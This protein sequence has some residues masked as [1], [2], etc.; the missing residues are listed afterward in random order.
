MIAALA[1]AAFICSEP[2]YLAAAKKAQKFLEEYLTGSN[3]RLF[4]RYCDG[5][6]A[7]PGHLD[8]YAFYA[9]ALTELYQSTWEIE[10]LHKAAFITKQMLHLFSDENS[11]GFYLYAIDAPQ[12][13]SRPKEVYD[14]A[15]PSGN[16]VAAQVLATLASLTGVEYWRQAR[17]HQMCFLADA[18]HDRPAGHCFALSAMCNILYPATNLLCVSAE[19]EM[20]KAMTDILRKK[21]PSNMTVLFKSPGNREELARLAPFTKE[22]PIPENGTL[23]YICRG[24]TCSA[25]FAN[26]EQIYDFL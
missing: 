4:I 16:S 18:I 6:A 15:L 7:F 11:K 2:Y 22:Y 1:K 5:K 14:G 21:M 12:L 20:P 9:Y 8:D 19:K 17:D 10:Y 25:S 3:G 26:A 23:Y 24:N 13:I